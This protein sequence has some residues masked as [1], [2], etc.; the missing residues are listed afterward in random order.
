LAEAVAATP[1]A[2]WTRVQRGVGG[3]LAIMAPTI[4]GLVAS[5]AGADPALGP[6]ID[7]GS[8]GCL[9]V[10]GSPPALVVAL[11]LRN[12]GRAKEIVLGDAGRF[13]AAG[14][15]GSLAFFEPA[16]GGLALGIAASGW[17]VI[18]KTKDDVQA[19][20]PYAYRTL[21]TRPLAHANVH[22]DF[23]QGAFA[24]WLER[25]AGV[26]W[27]DAKSFL[28]AKDAESRAAHGGREPDFGDARAIV[29]LLDG[30]VKAR[31]DA[32]AD[33]KSGM[34]DLDV[35]EEAIQGTLA[36]E[37]GVGASRSMIDAMRPGPMKVGSLPAEMFGV[38]V[39]QGDLAARKESARAV[40]EGVARVLGK[41]LSADDATKVGSALDA[42][43][44]ARGDWLG[45][46]LDPR[47]LVLRAAAADHASEATKDLV[48]LAD[49]PALR[50]PIETIAGGVKAPIAW[51]VKD[52][53]I[54]VAIGTK[55]QDLLDA[56][57][58][59]RIQVALAKLG[60]GASFAV[61]GHFLAP[62]PI[63][64]IAATRKDGKIQIVFDA[65]PVL[66]REILKN[67]TSM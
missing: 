5:L 6:E 66:V 20:G 43:A 28:L 2:S 14:E 36:L 11:R 64:T 31:V 26:K 22:A 46:G 3:L 63:S 38:L 25:T 52:G 1:D 17:I 61:A 15:V 67:L 33:L 55:A 18:G 58:D 47:G 39:T 59:E 4:G 29:E 54:Q 35:R 53:T 23:T 32:L 13:R 10:A 51:T 30:W 34:L 62:D 8:P 21:S 44:S 27:G 65:A 42:W 12:P 48:A 45:I 7:G 16:A 41:R 9:V 37:P 56:P 50:A 49:K 57:G 19:I 40:A 60:D 24:G